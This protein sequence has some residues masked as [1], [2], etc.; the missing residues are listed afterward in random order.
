MP[1]PSRLA[2][3]LWDWA[4]EGAYLGGLLNVKLELGEV[5]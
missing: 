5:G 1:G 2:A 3:M 4:K